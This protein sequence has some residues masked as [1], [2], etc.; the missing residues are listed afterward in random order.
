MINYS[1]E[2]YALQDETYEIIGLCM[3]VHQTL[4]RGFL[5]VVYKDALEYEFQKNKIPYEREKKYKVKYEDIILKYHFFADFVVYDKIILEAKAQQGV[6]NE[7]Y[8]WVLNYLAV[9]K[10]PIALL[11][12]FGLS[13]LF[14][15]RLIL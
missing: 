8:K 11:V 14:Y 9:S 7:H 2:K 10:L 13:S 3:K 12:N 15:K 4:G 1:R 6:S 5:E